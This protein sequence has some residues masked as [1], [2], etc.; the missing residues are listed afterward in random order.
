ML[1]HHWYTPTL[2]L[3]QR[4][5][6]AVVAVEM[7]I[8]IRRNNQNVNLAQALGDLVQEMKSLF[9]PLVED[10]EKWT[11][12]VVQSRANYVVHPGLKGSTD[13]H[14]LSLLSDSIYVLVVLTLL[15]ECGVSMESLGKIQ[16]HWHYKWL[17]G[18]LRSSA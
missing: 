18:K 3:E 1:V 15:R 5:F 10:P 12:E 14:R 7:L 6:H 11:R 9:E 16:N 8:R 2:Y 13:W 17:A 4:Y